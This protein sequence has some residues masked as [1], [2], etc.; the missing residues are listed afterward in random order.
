MLTHLKKPY[1]E[2]AKYINAATKIF[3]DR[4][5]PY[6]ILGKHCNYID[7]QEEA[8]QLLK[9]AYSI[10]FEKVKNKYMLFVLKTNYGKYIL[11]ELSV[12][13]FWTNRLHEGKKYLLQII[14][15]TDF[16]GHKDRLDKNLEHYNNRLKSEA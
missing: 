14:D 4:A 7:R 8:Y 11:D 13:C 15:D 1:E 5:E 9:K 12:A 3:P 10:D 6:Y 2:I 16:S